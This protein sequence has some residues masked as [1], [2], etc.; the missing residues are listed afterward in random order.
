MLDI[1]RQIEASAATVE[2]APVIFAIGNDVLG[3]LKVDSSRVTRTGKLVIEGWCVGDVTLSTSEAEQMLPVRLARHARPDV[4]QTLKV[5]EPE[6]GLGFRLETRLQDANPTA[7]IGL[8]ALVRNGEETASFDFALRP[9]RLDGEHAVQ[10]IKPLGFIESA[11]VCSVTGDTIIVGWLVASTDTRVFL[12][13][14]SGDGFLIEEHAFR[15]DRRDVWDAHGGTYGNAARNA[16]FIA[17]IQGVHVGERVNLVTEFS[18]KRQILSTAG[19]SLLPISPL[20][21][22]RALF[23]VT[24][25]LSDFHRRVEQIDRPILE[26][27]LQIQQAEWPSLEVK[28]RQLGSPPAAP[29][30]SVVV[31]LYGRSDFVEHQ[32]LEFVRDPWFR[33]HAELVYVIDDPALLEAFV[34]QAEALFRLYGLPFRWVWGA[35]NRGFSGANNLGAAH[36][37][38]PKIIFLNSDAF[39]R[40][41]GWIQPLLEVLDADPTV[42]AIGPRLVFADGSIQ[43]AGMEFLR[44]EEF[45]IWVNH[46]PWRGLDTA[47]DPA[48]G[49]S[50]LPAI[51]GACLAIT[52]DNFERI[53]GWDTGYLIGDFEDSDLCLK[54]RDQGFR[55]G[56]LPSVE[57]THLE[58]QSFRLLGEGQFRTSVVLF[59][60]FRHQSRWNHLLGTE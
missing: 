53:G 32:L 48:E 24:V 36:S 60:A 45:H 46:H 41:P 25:P 56:Y 57:L 23:G 1:T 10:R 30:V 34:P 43:H 31:P 33:A 14:E 12:E 44:R 18:G 55:I 51:T 5:E 35:V 16:A 4:S 20:G 21:A 59:N 6:G 2:E 7:P 8:T 13:N 49:L 54:L 58:R 52:R 47:L 26:R 28:V 15:Y 3:A 29:E 42:G 38:A 27:L 11:M 19:S 39:P 17:R 40:Q 22:A 50:F 9:E 37:S